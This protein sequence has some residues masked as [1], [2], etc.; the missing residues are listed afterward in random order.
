[1]I[2][3]LILFWLLNVVKGGD[4]VK[5]ANKTFFSFAINPL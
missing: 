3:L 5:I 1:M 2:W 4:G